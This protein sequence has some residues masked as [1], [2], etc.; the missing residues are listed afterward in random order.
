[1]R[2]SKTRYD[3]DEAMKKQKSQYSFLSAYR[4]VIEKIIRFLKVVYTNMIKRSKIKIV[5]QER[6][7]SVYIR[8][9]Y[10]ASSVQRVK[11]A[12]RYFTWQVHG[13]VERVGP[14]KY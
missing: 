9:E 7:S 4:Q 11:A 6:P 10:V 12:W 5:L 2:T 1:M 13:L 8:K 3:L 14:I